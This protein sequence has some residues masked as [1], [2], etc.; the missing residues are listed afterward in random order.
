MESDLVGGHADLKEDE[1]LV[2]VAH[3]LPD[4][5]RSFAGAGPFVSDA[6]A[7]VEHGKGWIATTG[8]VAP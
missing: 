6:M 3:R 5:G 7:A 8:Q 2:V 1:A 4:G